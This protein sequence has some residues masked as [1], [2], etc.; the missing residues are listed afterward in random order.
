MQIWQV[1][2]WEFENTKTLLKQPRK[3]LVFMTSQKLVF[4]IPFRRFVIER[5]MRSNTSNRPRL[6][7]YKR[8][9]KCSQWKSNPRISTWPQ[10]IPIC[11]CHL[12]K[13]GKVIQLSVSVL[14]AHWEKN[15]EDHKLTVFFQIW[16]MNHFSRK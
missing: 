14:L 7:Y 9:G 1:M 13:I 5:V 3:F 11:C 6:R 16:K 8:I 4:N 12:K 10:H 15:K 2:L